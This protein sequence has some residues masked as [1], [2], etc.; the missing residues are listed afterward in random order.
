VSTVQIV[1]SSQ[2]GGRHTITWNPERES[3]GAA[4]E[5]LA[6]LVL[7]TDGREKVGWQVDA[8]LHPT[9]DSWWGMPIK[10]EPAY[11]AWSTGGVYRV[12]TIGD[13]VPGEDPEVGPA[14]MMRGRRLRADKGLM[15]VAAVA[16]RLGVTP[17]TVRSYVARHQMPEP[18]ARF[19]RS[20]VWREADIEAWIASRPGQGNR[21]P[22]R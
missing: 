20:P 10:Y 18:Y 11:S 3:R 2:S 8:G 16:E 1:A 17:G 4:Y 13:D 6:R 21:T 7:G 9:W 15:D 22:R 5:R 14:E 19:G 12:D